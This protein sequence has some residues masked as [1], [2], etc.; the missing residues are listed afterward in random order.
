MKEVLGINLYTIEEVASLLGTHASS[1][2]RYIREGRMS[3]TLIGRTKYIPEVEIK[4]FVL[5]KANQSTGKV[6]PA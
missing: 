6:D 3:A 2:T 4:N 5:G 1:I